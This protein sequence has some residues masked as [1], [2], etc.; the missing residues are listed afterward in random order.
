MTYEHDHQKIGKDSL[1]TPDKLNPD[2]CADMPEICVRTVYAG[3]SSQGVHTYT[4]FHISM[5]PHYMRGRAK[6]GIKTIWHSSK[7]FWVDNPID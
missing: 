2:Y 7:P 6:R 3:K 5:L 1:Y 4:T